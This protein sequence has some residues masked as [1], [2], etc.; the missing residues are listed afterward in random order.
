MYV[1]VWTD[2]CLIQ[3]ESHLC[4]PLAL[5]QCRILKKKGFYTLTGGR[6]CEGITFYSGGPWTQKI[7]TLK[8][9]MVWTNFSR[10]LGFSEQKVP[11]QINTVN[12]NKWKD[13]R[14]YLSF[15]S[16]IPVSSFLVHLGFTYL[17]FGLFLLTLRVY[18]FIVFLMFVCVALASCLQTWTDWMR[19]KT[20]FASGS[21]NSETLCNV[22]PKTFKCDQ[23]TSETWLQQTSETKQ[24]SWKL[25]HILLFVMSFCVKVKQELHPDFA[26]SHRRW[27]THKSASSVSLKLVFVHEREK[28]NCWGWLI[29]PAIQATLASLKANI[30]WRL[31]VDIILQMRNRVSIMGVFKES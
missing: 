21:Q 22:T 1:D 25:W 13:S 6:C 3:K 4:Q 8:R 24:S 5:N 15:I 12:Q 18:S 28:I 31:I 2:W 9:T 14:F 29:S 19:Q 30:S 11:Q 20:Q 10:V 27:L 7:N 23:Q 26:I 17:S 16:N